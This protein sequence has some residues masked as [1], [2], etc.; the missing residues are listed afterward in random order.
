MSFHC[1][2]SVIWLALAATLVTTG[3]SKLKDAAREMQPGQAFLDSRIPAGL[4]PQYFPPDGFVWGAYRA[5]KLPQA[6]YGV[7]SPP[8]NPKA[9]IL[10]LADADYPAEVY[11]ETMR[12][13]LAEG[14]GVWL[15][16]APGQGGAG[17]YLLQNDSIY[18]ASYHD[19][20]ITARDFI[21]DIVKPS[22]EKPLFIVGTGYSAIA[23][24][25]LSTI[26]KDD[27]LRGFVAYAPY[28]G[29]PIAKGADWHRDAPQQGYFGGIAQTWQISNPD[30]RLRKKSEGWQKQMQKAYTDLSGLHL[31]VLSLKTGAQILV[32]QP[33]STS[34]ADGNAASA[35]CAR[36]PRCQ[37]APNDG[38]QAL[39]TDII[40]F[41]DAQTPAH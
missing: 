34:T 5:E 7:A 18:T 33:K 29:G 25:S 17:H 39:G 14:Y 35:L 16:E 27:N 23:A 15:L 22:G 21:N 26:L 9:Q 24:L 10:I 12:Q 8:I 37:V 2:K 36:L 13:L 40:A 38:P 11:F 41:V 3:C 1:P 19:A 28:L 32:L 4:S 31:P 6:R 20:Q 30:L